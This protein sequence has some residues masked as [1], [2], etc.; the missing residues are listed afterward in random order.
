MAERMTEDTFGA[1][2]QDLESPASGATAPRIDAP[3]KMKV[4]DLNVYYGEAHAIKD[5][6][7]DIPER[8]VTALMGPSGCGKSTFIRA[9][10]RMHDVTPGARVTGSVLLDGVDLYAPGTDIVSLRQRVGMVFQRPNPFPKSIFENVAYGLRI[11]GG[12]SRSQ[13]ADRVEQSLRGAALWDEVKDR[14]KKDA[15]GLSGGQQQRL[16]IARALAVEPEVIL[17]DEPASALDPIATLKIEELVEQLKEN[18]TIAIVTHNLQ[19]AARVSKYTGFFLTGNL[20][21]FGDT[22]ELFSRPRDKRT[23]DFIT[24]RFG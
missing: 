4:T 14:L 24:G 5:V 13:L 12:L 18:Y 17:M 20:I 22:K 15:T 7:M 1:T 2:I 21:E 8:E 3:I 10:N 6:S 23:E 16:C 9:L 19:Q 11:K